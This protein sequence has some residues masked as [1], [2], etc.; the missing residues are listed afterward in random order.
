MPPKTPKE[1]RQAQI[2]ESIEKM[3]DGL[4]DAEWEQVNE[5]GLGDGWEEVQKPEGKTDGETKTGESATE[6]GG[7]SKLSICFLL[8]VELF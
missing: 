8:N 7:R 4:R 1:A 6:K 2:N 3:K 5:D